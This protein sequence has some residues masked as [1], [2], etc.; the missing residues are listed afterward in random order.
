MQ[1]NQDTVL[2]A[3]HVELVDYYE[4]SQRITPYITDS[5]IHI[6]N[7]QNINKENNA[8]L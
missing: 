6:L 1:I 8:R 2:H 7:F 4:D 3:D 5:F